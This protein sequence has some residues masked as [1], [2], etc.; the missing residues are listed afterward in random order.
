MRQLMKNKEIDKKE[1]R[2]SD[3]ADGFPARTKLDDE[4]RAFLKA[5]K[6]SMPAQNEAGVF[7][8]RQSL[9][10]EHSSEPLPSPQALAEYKAV[11]PRLVDMFLTSWKNE[12]AH[13]H[14]MDKKLF[15]AQ[16]D[17]NNK[18]FTERK[19]GQVCASMIS[20]AA[21]ATAGYLGYIGHQAAACIVGGGTIVSIV[22]IFVT[23]RL[24]SKS[25]KN[26]IDALNQKGEESTTNNGVPPAE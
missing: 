21:F 11:D 17:Y 7:F 12:Q 20:L 3:K 15:N 4:Y 23:G 14:E 13:R 16:L 8:S 24:P 18:T 1:Q 25:K 5:A 26:V 9:Q 19:F 10:I 6:E 2:G 22:A